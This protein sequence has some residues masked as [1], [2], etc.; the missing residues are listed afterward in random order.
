MSFKEHYLKGA[1]LNE[2]SP[3]KAL[4]QPA[5][6]LS[7]SR[8]GEVTVETER[9]EELSLSTFQ[10]QPNN[11]FLSKPP[12]PSQL[13]KGTSRESYTCFNPNHTQTRSPCH[14]AIWSPKPQ[15][16]NCKP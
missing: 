8:E 1:L 2:R 15:T 5:L 14:S 16:L 11:T 7:T 13:G 10:N 9:P 4:D 12:A 3:R 6:L